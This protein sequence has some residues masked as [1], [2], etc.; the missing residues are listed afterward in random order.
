M[1]RVFRWC[2]CLLVLE[3]SRTLAGAACSTSQLERLATP[4]THYIAHVKVQAVRDPSIRRTLDASL[5]TMLFDLANGDA[6]VRQQ[7][8]NVVGDLLSATHAGTIIRDE[9]NGVHHRRVLLEFTGGVPSSLSRLANG[10][11]FRSY[12]LS[13]SCTGLLFSTQPSWTQGLPDGLRRPLDSV[14]TVAG[15]RGWMVGVVRP[16]QARRIASRLVVAEAMVSQV[17]AVSGELVG[18]QLQGR[19]YCWP[20][21]VNAVLGAVRFLEV[22]ATKNGDVV[23]FTHAGIS[24]PTVRNVVR[25]FGP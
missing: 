8:A 24:L 10:P 17:V 5:R 4:D 14:S 9:R 1:S 21:G 7:L 25:G 15:V 18:S 2:L 20:D 3:A 12:S 19:L 16:T 11:V 22:Q 6:T 13:P 23:H